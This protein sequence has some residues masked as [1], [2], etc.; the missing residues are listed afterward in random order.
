[1]ITLLF[2]FFYLLPSILELMQDKEHTHKHKRS[3]K[4]ENQIG[5]EFL[6]SNWFTFVSFL[7]RPTRCQMRCCS[8]SNFFSLSLNEEKMG[9]ETHQTNAGDISIKRKKS[10]P[11][12]G[13]TQVQY[14]DKVD[15]HRHFF[16]R[17][18]VCACVH[19]RIHATRARAKKKNRNKKIEGRPDSNNKECVI[20][21]TSSLHFDRRRPRFLLI[22]RR[23]CLAHFSPKHTKKMPGIPCCDSFPCRNYADKLCR[24]TWNWSACLLEIDLISCVT[25]KLFHLAANS[26]RWLVIHNEGGSMMP[27]SLRALDKP[28]SHCLSDARHHLNDPYGSFDV[29]VSHLHDWPQW[30]I[31]KTLFPVFNV[32]IRM[33]R[34]VFFRPLNGKPDGRRWARR[35]SP[36]AASVQRYSRRSFI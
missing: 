17:E 4:R 25:W 1:M 33:T 28:A 21:S 8:K 22:R 14:N 16:P 35:E 6:K 26:T 27:A 18:Y 24:F 30:E 19:V 7:Y 36:T 29:I 2:F 11:N 5:S 13:I 32:S 9:S 3:L 31:A 10:W 12:T 15:Q 34:C 20:I 23:Q